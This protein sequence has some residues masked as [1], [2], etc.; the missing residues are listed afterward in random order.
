MAYYNPG[1]EPENLKKKLKSLFEKLDSAYPDKIVIGLHNDH[2]KWGETVTTLYRELGYPD[3]KSFLEAYGYQY[4]RKDNPGGRPKSVDPEAIIKE[5][6]E[7]YP[8]G[9]PFKTA[10]ELFAGTEYESKLKTI[11]NQSKEVFGM[12]LGKY[13]LSIGLLQSKVKP[14][15]D[16]KKYIVCKVKPTAVERSF[17]YI[18]PLRSIHEGD[19]VEIP[20][21]AANSVVYGLVEEVI[22]CSR[23]TAP[24]DVDTVKTI[25]GKVGTREYNIGLFHSA[26]QANAAVETDQLI[27]HAS[28]S[29]FHEAKFAGP[30]MTGKILWAYC[31]GF[32]T[33]ILKALDYLVEKDKQIY[34]YRDLILLEPGV[35]GLFVYANDVEDVMARYPDIKMAM[36]AE[37]S[38]SGTADLC[39]S[40]SG[41]PMITESYT[42]GKCD[43]KSKTKWTVKHSPTEDFTEGDIRYTFRYRDDWDAVNYVYTDESGARRQLG[44]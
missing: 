30:K 34:E 43:I 31:K 16:T 17:Y 6:Q 27:E 9:S 24:C 15:E 36:F 1:M 41:Y 18:T 23:A 42:I 38:D 21:G 39:Y 7:K 29:A 40:R 44:K 35:S 25:L 11:M 32:S 22:N 14:K 5:F 4:G 13:L 19:H 8:N 20:L 37:N 3:G 26:L 10:E 28:V 33:E 2:K 12:P